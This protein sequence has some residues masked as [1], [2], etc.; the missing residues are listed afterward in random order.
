MLQ[1]NVLVFLPAQTKKASLGNLFV[2]ADSKTVNELKFLPTY[3]H[4]D[5]WQ[6]MIKRSTEKVKIS[7][8]AL[9]TLMEEKLAH[10]CVHYNAK[11]FLF[12]K[13]AVKWPVAVARQSNEGKKLVKFIQDFK[14]NIKQTQS[15]V[16]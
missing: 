1:E 16:Q 2:R 9:F 14:L 5:V 8:P 7:Q 4:L 13:P 10:Q 11:L 12:L 3:L 15:F 6:P